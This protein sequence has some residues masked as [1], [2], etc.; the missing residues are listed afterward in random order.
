M[1]GKREAE[2]LQGLVERTQVILKTNV[3]Y[4]GVWVDKALSFKRHIAQTAEKAEKVEKA[5]K[6]MAVVARLMPRV[7]GPRASKRRMVCGMVHSIL[8]CAVPLCREALRIGS[9]AAR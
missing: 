1:I 2:Q 6:S 8:L 7:G 9:Y 5:E 3:K 4:L